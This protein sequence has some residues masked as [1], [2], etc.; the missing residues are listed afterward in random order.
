VIQKLK[1]TDVRIFL[2]F[3]AVILLYAAPCPGQDLEIESVMPAYSVAY[4]A[5]TDVAGVWDMI[6]AS[7]LCQSLLSDKIAAEL[8]GVDLSKLAGIFDRRMAFLLVNMGIGIGQPALIAD[9]GDL[10]GAAEV[11]KE[12]ERTLGGS[13]LYEVQ[14]PAG[15]YK[16]ISFASLT[17]KGKKLTMRYAFLDNLF[18][19]ALKQD[20]FEAILD[21]YLGAD[22]SLIY[23]PGYNNA[24]A[25]VSADGEVFVYVNTE[26]L[27]LLSR[28]AR[29]S[30]LVMLLQILGLHEVK[31][32]AWTTG[33]LDSTREQEMYMYAEDSSS[34][35]I[36]P[37]TQ[38]EPLLSPHLIPALDT[39][40]FFATHLDD[41]TAT[42]EKFQD[43]VSGVMGEEHHVGMQS[44]ISD[45]ERETALNIKDD[46][47]SSLTGEIGFAMPT[48][49]LANFL[50]DRDH[51]MENG[52]MIFCGVSDRERCAMSIER[53]LSAK[54]VLV[55]QMEYSGVTIYHILAL[56]NP[57]GYMFAGDLLVFGGVHALE[58]IIDEEPPLVVSEK[59]AWISS[60][61]PQHPGLMYYL[62]LSEVGKLLL[63][64]SQKSQSEDDAI[65]L[66]MLG[67]IGGI[68]I[69]DEKGIK[70]R[71]TG[72]PS[73][74]WLETIGDLAKLF[75]RTSF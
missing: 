20:V 10:E 70:A 27:W 5:I 65:H 16:T 54:K 28:P 12:I 26:L 36:L 56:S 59:F 67:S 53:I 6:T 48:A 44:A 15:T 47:L 32:V 60:Q 14:S 62:N 37:T 64:A 33:L 18:V 72:T 21:V 43:A 7:P 41:P 34:L 35:M 61:L 25:K 1:K 71:S 40:I 57:I 2:C 66:Q 8:P 69:R 49:E 58:R 17:H 74:S 19:L 39:D 45:F 24:R 4:A 38:N 68:L 11:V 22:L 29:D 46:I 50:W 9:V 51:L 23:D 75:I 73:R 3:F 55:Q 63:T 31:S 52:L 13:A 30:E 42:W